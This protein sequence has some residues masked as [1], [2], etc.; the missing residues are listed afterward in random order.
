MNAAQLYLIFTYNVYL[1]FRDPYVI[2]LRSVALPS[3][4]PT[5]EFHRG[6]VVCAGFTIYEVSKSVSKVGKY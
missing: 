3:H 5:E 4:P 1:F 6:E 2:A